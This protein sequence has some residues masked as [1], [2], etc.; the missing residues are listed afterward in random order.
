MCD[1]YFKSWPICGPKP[2][3]RQRDKK[4]KELASDDAL[5]WTR[6]SSRGDY[7]RWSWLVVC[8]KWCFKLVYGIEFGMPGN[9][10]QTELVSLK[11]RLTAFT[12]SGFATPLSTPVDPMLA[13]VFQNR[14]VSIAG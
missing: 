12:V 10:P 6:L 5:G 9:L 13:W 3:Y 1:V 7:G 11:L 2:G 14:L 4:V 8:W